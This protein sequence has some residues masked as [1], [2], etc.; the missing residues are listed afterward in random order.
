MRVDQALNSWGCCDNP[1]KARRAFP[2]CCVVVKKLSTNFS[3]FIN[4]YEKCFYYISLWFIISISSK[5]SK[6]QHWKCSLVPNLSI[7]IDN[8]ENTLIDWH[9]K[10]DI[11]TPFVVV[12]FFGLK[13][14]KIRISRSLNANVNSIN[15]AKYTFTLNFNWEM[16]ISV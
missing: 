3:I 10:W 9:L 11:S 14:S 5:A 12:I 4:Q 8:S 15:V 13:I 1:A 6:A 2:M 16:R 7:K